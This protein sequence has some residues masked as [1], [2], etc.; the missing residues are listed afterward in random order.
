M[1]IRTGLRTAAGSRERVRDELS[2]TSGHLPSLS[3]ENEEPALG[4]D[5][6]EHKVASLCARCNPLLAPV[7]G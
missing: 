1:V 3:V 7:N 5:F 2:E 6:N 4:P